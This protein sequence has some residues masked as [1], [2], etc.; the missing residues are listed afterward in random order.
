[1]QRL[2]RRCRMVLPVP[3]E[4]CQDGEMMVDTCK[5][6]DTVLQ[7]CKRGWRVKPQP[8]VLLDQLPA[9]QTASKS[10]GAGGDATSTGQEKGKREL[11]PA[12]PSPCNAAW[13]G[14]GRNGLL[15]HQTALILASAAC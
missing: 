6:G 12:W 7:L 1:M 9:C 13:V 11:T 4:V 3:G 10:L 15:L 2:P 5:G 14:E 8:L